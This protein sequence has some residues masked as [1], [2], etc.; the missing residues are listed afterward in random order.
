MS[1]IAETK[2]PEHRESLKS[3]VFVMQARH[4]IGLKAIKSWLTNFSALEGNA[5]E[6]DK[7]L[8]LNSQLSS[9]KERPISEA[10][11]STPLG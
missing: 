5:I 9:Y 7:T 6:N 1:K 11:R 2:I 4:C 10:T 8:L 3:G